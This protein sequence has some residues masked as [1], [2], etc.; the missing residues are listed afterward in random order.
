MASMK[1][2]CFATSCAALNNAKMLQRAPTQSAEG[3]LRDCERITIRADIYLTFRIPL[4]WDSI[5]RCGV[6]FP[7]RRSPSKDTNPIACQRVAEVV[8]EPVSLAPATRD[9]G[10]SSVER[11]VAAFSHGGFSRC[12]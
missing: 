3:G 5:A 7:A 2:W 6:A 11:I 12:G 10:S 4:G 8:A 1:M 9:R